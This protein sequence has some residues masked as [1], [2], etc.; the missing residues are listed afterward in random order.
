MKKLITICVAVGLMV[1]ATSAAYALPSD[2]FS[3][4]AMDTTL[5]T[6]FEENHAYAWLD[7]IYGRLEFRTTASADDAAALY[8]ANDWGFVPTSDF[9][10]KVGFHYS[11][12]I[13][14]SV[15]LGLAKDIEDN[16]VWLEAGY[17][18]GKAHFCWDAFVDGSFYDG[19]D[20]KSRSLDGGTLY[21]SYDATE[22][23]L[24]LSDSGY[25]SGSAWGTISGLVQG[26]WGA[27]MVSPLLGGSAGD[28]GE[29]LPS[30]VA[31]LDNFVVDSGTIIPEPATIALLGLGSLSLLR[32]KAKA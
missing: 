32:R 20:G 12:T 7:E 31:Y 2:D 10:F 15:L 19:E 9:S 29:A 30:G 4:D 28:P 11:S 5:W 18:E 26:A 1:F 22:D 27:D 17:G 3:D 13:S 14:G 6:L 8:I 16:D 25:G 24:Y 23:E 21:I